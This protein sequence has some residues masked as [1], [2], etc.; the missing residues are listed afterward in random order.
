MLWADFSWNYW[1]R[2]EVC[3]WVRSHRRNNTFVQWDSWTA[4]QEN[5]GTIGLCPSLP[6]INW[7]LLML[8][9]I[10]QGSSHISCVYKNW[11]KSLGTI[12]KESMWAHPGRIEEV[13]SK[14]TH[15]WNKRKVWGL[16]EKPQSSRSSAQEKD[17]V[18]KWQKK[19]KKRMQWNRVSCAGQGFQT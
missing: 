4:K 2:Q 14:D 17:N 16:W 8:P 12:S 1:G 9:T 6:W 18:G 13:G 7:W 5:A 19:W 3:N 15:K 11:F 10:R